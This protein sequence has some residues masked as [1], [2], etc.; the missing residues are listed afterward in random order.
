MAIFN[1]ATGSPFA[2][3]TNPVSNATADL[4]G[5]GLHSTFCSRTTSATT[6]RSCSATVPAASPPARLLRS[7]TARARWKRA[8]STA[9]A[10]STSWP[11]TTAATTSR[12]R[13]TT[14][15]GRSTTTS[16]AVGT[17]PRGLAI[18][19]LDGD[20]DLDFV[21]ANY[22]S[23]NLSVDAQQRQRGVRARPWVRPSQWGPV[24]SRSRWPI[25]TATATS[26]LPSPAISPTLSQS[27]STTARAVLS[28]RRRVHRSW[29][30]RHRGGRSRWRWR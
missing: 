21:A 16:V 1:P 8:T 26:I 11:P 7:A 4:N 27:C 10:T 29:S 14:A 5:D 12:W 22:Q 15:P 24:R 3:G 6:S 30:P 2:T 20:G 28:R 19:D 9:T 18:A 25:S 23:N 13:A 17:V